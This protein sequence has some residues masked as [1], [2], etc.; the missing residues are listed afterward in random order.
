MSLA[1]FETAPDLP[2]LEEVTQYLAQLRRPSMARH[3][4]DAERSGKVLIQPRSGTGSQRGMLALLDV[5][6]QQGAADCLTLTIDSH[7]RLLKFTTAQ[8][9]RASFP[10]QLNGYPLVAHGYRAVREISE[11]Y[12]LPIQVRHGSPDGRRLFAE[13]VAGGIQSYEGGGIGY[14]LPYCRNVPL[15]TSLRDWQQIDQ[16]CGVLESLGFPI[17][18]EFFG[19]LSSVLMPPSISLAV[20]LLEAL[21]A[22]RAG[23][24]CLSLA[25]PQS[26]NLI[27]DVAALQTIRVLGRHYLGEAVQVYP[28][29]HEFMGVFPHDVECAQTLIFFGG[30]T[31]RLG[32]ATKIINKTSQEATGIPDPEVNAEGIRRTRLAYQEYLSHVTVDPARVQEEA[33]WIER[34]TCE[35]IDPL[36]SEPEL[37]PAIVK[38]FHDGR[39]DIP[40]PANREARGRVVPVRDSDIAIRFADVGNLPFS[41]AVKAHNRSKCKQAWDG[42]PI[43]KRVRDS[44]M[45]FA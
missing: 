16:D 43:F 34:E 15:E 14:N 45:Y 27:Q 6:S 12:D 3:L 17:D 19:S 28:V 30:L 42:G 4:A 7:T 24:T 21:L 26:C 23:C 37:I 2:P 13:S 35:Q 40:F 41:H 29:L 11:R 5:L 18:R 33:Y 8:R 31:G 38:A 1:C 39:L 22:A 32:R 44:I 20:V 9:L 36:L 25:Y 10:E